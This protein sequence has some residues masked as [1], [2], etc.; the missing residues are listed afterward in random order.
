MLNKKSFALSRRQMIGISGLGTVVGLPRVAVAAKP[1]TSGQESIYTRIGVR[2]FINMTTSYTINGGTLTFPEVKRAMDEASYHSVNIDELMEKAGERISKLMGAEAAIVS[3]GCAAALTHA[4][5]ACV[6]GADPEKMQQLPDLD[7]MKDQVLM[8]KQSRNA[9]DHAIRAV[10]VKIIEFNSREE[11]Q[12]ALSK[13][14]A[15]IAVNASAEARGKLGLEEIAEAARQAGIPILVDAAAH[16]PALPNPFLSRGADL[17]AYSGGKIL[18]G[19]QCAGLLIGRKDLVSAAWV[20]SSPHHALGRMMK[21]GKEE[22]MGM[23]AAMEYWAGKRDMQAEYRVLHTWL[24]HIT[25]K[26]TRVRG[27]RTRLAPPEGPNPYPVMWVEWDPEIIGLT[28]GE[29]GR[30]LMEGEPRI[31]SHAEGEGHAFLI[32]PVSMKPGDYK[33]AAARLHEIFSSAPKGK[34]APGLAP[35]SVNIAGQWDTD[36]EFVSGVSRRTLL[37]ETEGNRITGTHIGW[38]LRGELAGTI[39]GDQIRIRSSF[40]YEGTRL[41]YNFTGRVSGDSMTGE[42]DLGEYGRARWTARRQA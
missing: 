24:A 41:R 7:G 3:S 1:A 14:V 39:D 2:P 29:L 19:P 20:N 35:P 18:Q 34:P 36:M 16:L 5:A 33:L 21:V 40:P 22:I 25:E 12:A 30:M 32:R 42:V 26:I 38:K 27:V 23:L 11:F 4:T 31:A 8:P 9:Y 15:M 13:R 10:G 17:V 28:A 37:L 6:A